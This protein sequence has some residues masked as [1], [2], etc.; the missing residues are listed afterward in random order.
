MEDYEAVE[1]QEEP[2]AKVVMVFKERMKEVTKHKMFKCAPLGK[3]CVCVAEE[4][5]TKKLRMIKVA[6]QFRWENKFMGGQDQNR[7]V[8]FLY[9]LVSHM[10]WVLASLSAD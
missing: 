1:C 7:K 10:C 4:S 5:C 6:V 3:Q 8:S 2:K 9:Y